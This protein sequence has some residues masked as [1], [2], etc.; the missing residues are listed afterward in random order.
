MTAESL[1]AW[2][3]LAF[4]L[5]VV[6]IFAFTGIRLRGATVG[7]AVLSWLA[8]R[9]AMA[10]LPLLLEWINRHFHA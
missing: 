7:A 6:L 5:W 10:W 3:L 4:G 2:A 8:A 1:A 9:A